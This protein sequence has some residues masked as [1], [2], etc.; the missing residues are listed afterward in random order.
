M[1]P[2]LLLAAAAAAAGAIAPAR[3]PPAV[4]AAGISAAGTSAAAA[5]AAGLCAIPVSRAGTGLFFLCPGRGQRLFGPAAAEE[6]LRHPVILLQLTGLER[7]ARIALF[8]ALDGLVEKD[9]RLGAIGAVRR[10]GG[11]VAGRAHRVA[12]PAGRRG[13][14][15]IAQ[16]VQRLGRVFFRVQQHPHTQ[17]GIQLLPAGFSAQ[18][19]HSVVVI[20]A[21]FLALG[22]VLEQGIQ[23]VGPGLL[24]PVPAQQLAADLIAG[25]LDL[26]RRL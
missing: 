21:F 6:I 20:R 14:R 3:T 9:G 8:Q 4:C 23:A 11:F 17:G 19:R 7:R 13:V 18:V 22:Q 5:L 1:H 15:R 2:A 26:K 12:G 24:L 16:Q 10:V 25:R